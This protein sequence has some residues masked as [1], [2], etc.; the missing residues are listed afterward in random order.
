MFKPQRLYFPH[1]VAH[2][3]AVVDIRIGSMSYM[4]G[5]GEMPGSSFC[6]RRNPKKSDRLL[7]WHTVQVSQ[8]VLVNV[9][10]VF[11]VQLCIRAYLV[12]L[13]VGP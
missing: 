10:N 3:I 12:G 11:A 9:K 6:E 13:T 2:S 5:Q 8:R 7:D 1:D 4:A